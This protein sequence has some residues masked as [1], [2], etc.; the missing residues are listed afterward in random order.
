MITKPTSRIDQLGGIAKS[1]PYCIDRVRHNYQPNCDRC[2]ST[3]LVSLIDYERYF[4][5]KYDRPID[6]SLCRIPPLLKELRQ[7]RENGEIDD[8]IPF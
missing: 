3:G 2:D 7:R 1:C 6:L 5:E 8:D 4:A